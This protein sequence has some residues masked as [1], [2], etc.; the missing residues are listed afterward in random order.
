L[1]HA[2]CD[3]ISAHRDYF[4]RVFAKRRSVG[5]RY[6]EI[7]NVCGAGEIGKGEVAQR[8]AS[9]MHAL[10]RGGRFF[11][12]ADQAQTNAVNSK[13]GGEKQSEQE[14]GDKHLGEGHGRVATA[15]SKF[16]IYHNQPIA[17]R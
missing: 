9:V 10:E 1:R 12:S 14:E 11:G 2:A 17:F 7:L 3:R 5:G 6:H 8:L 16:H 13:D 4:R 15:V